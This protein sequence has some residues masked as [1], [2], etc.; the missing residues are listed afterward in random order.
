MRPAPRAHASCGCGRKGR[1]ER[2]RSSA[3]RSLRLPSQCS[4]PPVCALTPLRR[5]RRLRFAWLGTVTPPSLSRPNHT[6]PQQQLHSPE[7]S[8]A[9]VLAAEPAT[10]GGLES[11]VAPPPSESPL[12]AAC[13]HPGDARPPSLPRRR[14]GEVA[15][16]YST[17][18]EAVRKHLT[19]TSGR[20]GWIGI[21]GVWRRA[22]QS[23]PAR[24]TRR[25]CRCSRARREVENVSLAL[26]HGERRRFRGV[27]FL[28][29]VR[30][31]RL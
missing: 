21:G 9:S 29:H 12:R 27:S 31:P 14:C 16:S 23:G 11:R 4:P 1:V 6:T 7:W 24:W 28:T 5:L 25:R 3:V 22:D 19:L 10:D 8:V 15:R 17:R 26:A 30:R 20:A 18:R 2:V 13:I